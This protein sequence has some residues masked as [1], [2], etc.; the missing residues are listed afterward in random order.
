MGFW[1]KG[2]QATHQSG[3]SWGEWKSLKGILTSGP[4]VITNE[5]GT[6]D[7]FGRGPDRHVW[8][9]HQYLTKAGLQW[10]PWQD[11]GGIST[12]T[13]SV[14]IGADNMLNLF[15]RGPERAIWTRRQQENL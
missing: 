9:K 14:A 4:S 15:F 1:I 5:E 13:P 3:V 2:Q 6:L 11:M 8:M 7:V 10:T 12:A